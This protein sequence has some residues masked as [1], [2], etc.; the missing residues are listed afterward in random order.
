MEHSAEGAAANASVVTA[1]R[2][3]LQ[4]ERRTDADR[5]ASGGRGGGTEG[6]ARYGGGCN[7]SRSG[8]AASS[9]AN[10]SSAAAGR[11]VPPEAELG[12][13]GVVQQGAVAGSEVPL[14]QGDQACSMEHNAAGQKRTSTQF[15]VGS[16]MDPHGTSAPCVAPAGPSAADPLHASDR[17]EAPPRSGRPA[18]ASRGSDALEPLASFRNLYYRRRGLTDLED[19]ADDRLGMF[20]TGLASAGASRALYS[21]ETATGA[22][23]MQY[24]WAAS[25]IQAAW[26]R[27]HHMRCAAATSIQAAWRARCVRQ[28][29]AEL[30]KADAARGREEWL[31]AQAAARKLLK[32]QAKDLLLALY[33]Q[34]QY[35][36]TRDRMLQAKVRC[37]GA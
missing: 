35:S 30:A 5:D 3:A 21:W 7:S 9:F 16:C 32:Q 28:Q 23:L 33:A 11:A 18:R 36:R 37:G 12:Q 31:R 4:S 13:P 19:D 25:V 29:L 20:S 22:E 6:A 15:S 2:A 8:G 27:H 17:L 34:G 26:R 1:G 14:Q 10:G 24:H